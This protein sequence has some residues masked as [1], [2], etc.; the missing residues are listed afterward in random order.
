M[1]YQIYSLKFIRILKNG[2]T[3]IGVV[4]LGRDAIDNPGSLPCESQRLRFRR[5]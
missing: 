5:A 4:R 3:L 1:V 2:H